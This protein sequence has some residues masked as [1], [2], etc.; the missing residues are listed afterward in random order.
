MLKRIFWLKEGKKSSTHHPSNE[1]NV[2][3]E[4]LAG[5]KGHQGHID[6]SRSMQVVTV[7]LIALGLRQ[8]TREGSV[9]QKHYNA[10]DKYRKKSM[11]SSYLLYRIPKVKSDSPEDQG[12]IGTFRLTARAL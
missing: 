12:A 3:F 8:C 4:A 2:E 1:H 6:T 11:Y 10:L 5:V 9:L 7:A